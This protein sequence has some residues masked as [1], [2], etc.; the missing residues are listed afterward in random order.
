MFDPGYH[1]PS[2]QTPLSAHQLSPYLPL[3]L[4]HGNVL[5]LLLQHHLINFCMNYDCHYGES[6]W[7]DI[8]CINEFLCLPASKSVHE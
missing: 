1:R 2:F 8:I 3:V 5:A 7:L 6:E 4:M